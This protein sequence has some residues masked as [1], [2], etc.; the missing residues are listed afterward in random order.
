[1]G[2]FGVNF[3]SNWSG[4]A[5]IVVI[6]PTASQVISFTGARTQF[7]LVLGGARG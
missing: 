6:P 7:A 5:G 3:G 2:N 4:V 1:M